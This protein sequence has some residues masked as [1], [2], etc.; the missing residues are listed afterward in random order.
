L[1]AQSSWVSQGYESHEAGPSEMHQYIP[2]APPPPPPPAP[3][4]AQDLYAPATHYHYGQYLGHVSFATPRYPQVAV[5]ER[6]QPHYAPSGLAVPPAL[7]PTREELERFPL[8]NTLLT[9]L[10]GYVPPPPDPLLDAPS[11]TYPLVES[12]EGTH[13][14]TLVAGVW[15]RTEHSDNAYAYAHNVSRR[16]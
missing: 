2:S 3:T 6:S 10:P 5:E 11:S 15:R 7:S 13:A 8:D 9:P 4:S 12:S 14:A 16:Q 1:S